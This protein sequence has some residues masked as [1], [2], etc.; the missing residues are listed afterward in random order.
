MYLISMVE[1][2]TKH[3]NVSTNFFATTYRE[4][5]ISEHKT[6]I[7]KVDMTINHYVYNKLAKIPTDINSYDDDHCT[8]I[9][10]ITREPFNFY[11]MLNH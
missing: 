4:A 3:Q 11:F 9:K 5:M 2:K 6:H 8:I 1:T 7:A 10:E